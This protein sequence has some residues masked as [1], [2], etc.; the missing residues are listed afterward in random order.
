MAYREPQ[1]Q[2]FQDFE[3]ALAAGAAPLHAIYIGPK[4][5]LHR[6]SVEAE[7]AEVGEYDH[8][9]PSTEFSWP[10]HEAGGVIDL[11]TAKLI[12]EDG[13]MRYLTTTGDFNTTVDNNNKVR[14]PS[15]I[16][17]TNDFADADSAFG[18]REVQVGDAAVVRW[19]NPSTLLLET[20]E[21]EI[22]GFEADVVP[23]TT[24][25]VNVRV[26]GFGSTVAGATETTSPPTQF[27]TS[28]VF[29][30]YDGLADGFPADTY[31]IK[32]VAKG[33]AG[34][35]GLDG[36]KL[37][38]TSAGGDNNT[39][40]LELGVDVLFA[41]GDYDV[42][43]GARGAVLKLID[44]GAGTFNVGDEWKVLISQTYTEVDVTD[45]LQFDT[46]GPYTGTRNT[47]Y[48]L[49]VLTG[50]TIAT[51]DLIIKVSTNNG[52][53]ATTQFS[54]PA[55]DFP[56]PVTYPVGT[57][58]MTVTFF[59]ATEFNTGDVIAFDVEGESEGEI[60]TLILR[61]IVSAI[62]SVALDVDLL[63]KQTID[64]PL[65][66][67]EIA[68]DLITVSGSAE[69][70][71][72]LLDKGVDESFPIHGGT[73]FADYRE[74]LT[75]VANKL[76][77]EDTLTNAV[78][79][80]GPASPLNPI[81]LAVDLGLK[82]SG[83]IKV[84]WIP[85]KTDDV[86][87]YTDALDLSTENDEAYSIVV[88]TNDDDVRQ[89]VKGHILE[90]SNENNNQWRIAWFGNNTPSV[91]PV[92]TES[93]GD[94]IEAT[95]E[96]FGL[97]LFRKVVSVGAQFESNGVQA[98]D[99]L[100]INF[101]TDD[102]DNVTYDE[103]TIDRVED[104]DTIILLDS[105]DAEITVAVKIE[106]WRAL[107]K[108]QY[109]DAL[110]DF[111]ASYNNRRIYAVFADGLVQSDNTPLDLFYLAA[112]LA[113]QRSGVAPHAPLSQVDVGGIF[114]DPQ[115]AFSRSQLNT[116]ASGG[117]W[118]VVKD[119]VTGRI[120]TRHQV[121]TLIDP[122]DLLEREQSVTTN[123]DHI[124]RDFLAN[125]KDLFGQGNVSPEMVALIRQRVNSLI[126]KISN[127]PYPAKI[128]PQ[129]IGAEIITLQVDEVLRD[130]ILVEIDP[131]LPVPLNSLIIRFKIN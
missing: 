91:I 11:N 31:T 90:R 126:E 105:L 56:G 6:Y 79:T 1:L 107:A 52:A 95:V 83:S 94:D 35:G 114:M 123:V 128:G 21:T 89:L 75:A 130:T 39:T 103:F 129:M 4:Y 116:I 88:L 67:Y 113:G 23:G 19:I 61:D 65:D 96:E 64:F 37:R 17:K 93:D 72:D 73:L 2:I 97:D 109:A 117:V 78:N 30:S 43:L 110:G 50:G 80:A 66:S 122:D 29:A 12:L 100:R 118:I 26:V 55:A 36:T 18:E 99:K 68:Q 60:H 92:Y 42:P 44:A 27:T 7:K 24:D 28:Y 16:F 131:E 48:R 70:I 74:L 115:F 127:R 25:P 34:V 53:D 82:N 62:T 3:D 77:S 5:G 111:A 124:S 121:S 106:I 104:E 101:V 10:D 41:G 86:A 46:T 85:V 81:G 13:L 54:V 76:Y 63:I 38:V 51:D 45:V 84:F 14:D 22:I 20:L 119:P 69:L 108:D 120:F 49:T 47:Q 15:R 59:D 40:D 9:V 33:T 112:A 87:G 98:G 58:G 8:T 102:E 125:T 71:A 32:V 57:K